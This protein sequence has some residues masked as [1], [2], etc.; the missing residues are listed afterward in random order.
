MRNQRVIELNTEM[1]N[2]KI[3]I[4]AYQSLGVESTNPEKKIYNVILS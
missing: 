3:L 2:F 4:N 1:V